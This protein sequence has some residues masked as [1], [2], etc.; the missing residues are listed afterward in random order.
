M[1]FTSHTNMSAHGIEFLPSVQR[2]FSVMCEVFSERPTHVT[3]FR[4]VNK[5]CQKYGFTKVQA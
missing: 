2:R 1:C 4:S 3:E 5:H